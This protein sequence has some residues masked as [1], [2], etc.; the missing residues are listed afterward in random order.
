LRRALPVALVWGE[1][2]GEVRL[3]P[4]AQVI[5]VIAAIFERFAAC[6]S[7]RY[8]AVAARPGPV[9]SAAA[10][11]RSGHHLGGAQ[12][13]RGAQV[14]TH[15]AYAGAYVYGKTRHE[16]YVDEHGVLRTRRRKLA[17]TDWEVLIPE[18]H[19]GFID[20]DTHQAN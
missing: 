19:P 20:W 17:R 2:P 15:P 16:R 9:V 3:H 14:L 4:D 18:H 8:L 5:G 13:S 7:A 6:G 11:R 10:G 1:E 12:L